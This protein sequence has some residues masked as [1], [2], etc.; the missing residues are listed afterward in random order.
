MNIIKSFDQQDFFADL[1]LPYSVK[2]GE[3]FPLNIT[4][5]N[6]MD[7]RGNILVFVISLLLDVRGEKG[8]IFDL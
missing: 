4:L 1:R 6:Y 7:V 2:R 3:V 5:F 8:W